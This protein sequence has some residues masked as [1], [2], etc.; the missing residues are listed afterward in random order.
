MKA[1]IIMSV[2]FSFA[3]QAQGVDSNIYCKRKSKSTC[4][5]RVVDAFKK[6]GCS[7][8]ADSV[9]CEARDT[10]SGHSTKGFDSCS[11]ISN[12][13]EADVSGMGKIGCREGE[14]INMSSVD[15]KLS[16]TTFIGIFWKKVT[17]LCKIN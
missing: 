6:L 10:I 8:E 14:L 17:K 5:A 12:C 11:I 9:K 7:P 13:K 4:E 1:L 2:L 15:S 3:A 16:T